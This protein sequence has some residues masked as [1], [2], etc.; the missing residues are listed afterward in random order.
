MASSAFQVTPPK[1]PNLTKEERSDY[2]AN[3]VA[4]NNNVTS[5]S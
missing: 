4:T 2:Y 1:Q 5:Y 3:Q